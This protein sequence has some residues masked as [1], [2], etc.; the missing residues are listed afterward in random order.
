M[1]SS[2]P[3]VCTGRVPDVHTH[4]SNELELRVLSQATWPRAQAIG[5]RVATSSTEV[6]EPTL[7]SAATKALGSVPAGPHG[8]KHAEPLRTLGRWLS[9]LGDSGVRR[10]GGTA[11]LQIVLLTRT[12]AAKPGERSCW[13]GAPGPARRLSEHTATKLICRG[14]EQESQPQVRGRPPTRRVLGQQ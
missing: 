12:P 11:H 8:T 7:R 14:Q 10:R 6:T 4:R 9:E 3:G 2:G 13:R 5:S 1:Q